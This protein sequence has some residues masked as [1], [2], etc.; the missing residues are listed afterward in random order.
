M[1]DLI[2]KKSLVDLEYSNKKEEIK[3]DY[4]SQIK[5]LNETI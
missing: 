4:E 3:N 5:D 2:K 1:Q